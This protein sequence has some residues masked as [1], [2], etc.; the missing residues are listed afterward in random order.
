GVFVFLFLGVLFVF[1]FL[2]GG[3][4][5]VWGLGG[6]GFFFFLGGFFF[7]FFFGCVGAFVGVFFGVK[8]FYWGVSVAQTVGVYTVPARR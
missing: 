8:F 1:G 5:V 2:G 4:G 3:V 6:F 7:F